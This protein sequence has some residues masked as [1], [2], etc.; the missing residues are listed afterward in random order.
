MHR[1]VL[2]WSGYTMQFRNYWNITTQRY[3][4]HYVFAQVS[5]FWPTRTTMRGDVSYSLKQHGNSEGQAVFGL[6]IAQSL[7]I[8]TSLSLRYQRRST[9]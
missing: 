4:D 8:N 6:Q 1:S 9:F 5:K 2:L 7:G 3:M